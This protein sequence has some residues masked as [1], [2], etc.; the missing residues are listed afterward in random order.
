MEVKEFTRVAEPG[1]PPEDRYD[2]AE[3]H[4][5]AEATPSPIHSR[6]A[7]AESEAAQVGTEDE[8]FT[9]NTP[10]AEDVSDSEMAPPRVTRP[11]PPAPNP[12]APGVNTEST[13]ARAPVVPK[14]ISMPPPTRAVPVLD[15]SPPLAL[16]SSPQRTPSKRASV[17]PPSRE[18]SVP[19]QE[20]PDASS[21][22]RQSPTQRSSIA[23]PSRVA[24]SPHSELL[25][26][27]PP[28][29]PTF[30]VIDQGRVL[31]REP[32]VLPQVQDV[33]IP[34][35][36]P[37]LTPKPSIP[38]LT[39][40]GRKSA[41]S[42]RSA[43]S[44]HSREERRSS[45]QYPSPGVPVPAPLK[46]RAPTS[47]VPEQGVLHEDIIDGDFLSILVILLLLIYRRRPD[48]STAP[49]T[50]KVAC[51]LRTAFWCGTT[52]VGGSPPVWR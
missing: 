52:Y 50:V 12:P 48:R 16:G 24:L 35:P 8:P 34:P 22:R 17:P 13:I 18:M 49:H 3:G 30:G 40:E 47:L 7:T 46:K 20:S 19:F 37:V 6:S 4:A 25:V 28:P 31:T 44:R 5:T 9:P 39:P 43:D 41:E 1:Q 36:P 10:P 21:S 29:P 26:P 42:R 51:S 15:Y 14:R 23:T 45:G 38:P 32:E 33:P 11:L 2:E 27:P